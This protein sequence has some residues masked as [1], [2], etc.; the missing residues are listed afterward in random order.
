VHAERILIGQNDKQKKKSFR[1]RT[2]RHCHSRRW[3]CRFTSCTSSFSYKKKIIVFDDPESPR[4]AASHGIH[5]FLGLDGLLPIKIHEIAWEQIDKYDSVE[6]R[7]RNIVDV[8]KE[9]EY[10]D[11]IFVITDDNETSIKA[12]K[13]VLAVGCRDVYPDIPGFIECWADTIFH[14]H[15]VTVTKIGT[16]FG[17]LW[18]IPK[19]NLVGFRRWHKTGL[20]KLKLS[21][22]QT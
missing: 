18:R 1:T 8:N 10:E 16:V 12:K 20:L 2:N 7:N 4:N 19:R 5:N 22:L 3:T 6:F 17:V 13:V 11:G 9:E 14:A 15:F 21:Y